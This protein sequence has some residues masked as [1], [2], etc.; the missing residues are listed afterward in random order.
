MRLSSTAASL[1]P[2]RADRGGASVRAAIA[3]ATITVSSGCG[4]GR[5]MDVVPLEAMRR[6]EAQ[7]QRQ[8]VCVSQSAVI[9]PRVVQPVVERLEPCLEAGAERQSFLR[10]F[11]EQV[12]VSEARGHQVAVGR[13]DPAAHALRVVAGMG[14]GE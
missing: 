9:G 14:R 1:M 4:L 2:A 5:I 3:A 12:L 13:L 8:P 11:L 10:V 7:A 6:L